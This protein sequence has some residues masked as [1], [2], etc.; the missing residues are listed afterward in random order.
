MQ[1]AQSLVWLP[2]Q[3]LIQIPRWQRHG[4]ADFV[5][6]DPHPGFTTGRAEMPVLDMWCNTFRRAM[7]IVAERSQRNV[8]QHYW[9]MAAKLLVVPY[10]PATSD[11]AKPLKAGLSASW[12]H[13]PVVHFSCPW[14]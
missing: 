10:V 6:Y 3:A 5:F 12:L 13:I 9:A 4:G 8:C 14:I 2:A 1:L 11:V 7:H